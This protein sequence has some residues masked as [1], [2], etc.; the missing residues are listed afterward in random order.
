LRDDI[1]VSATLDGAHRFLAQTIAPE[2]ER[3]RANIEQFAKTARS[4]REGLRNRF[5]EARSR[6]EP[7]VAAA[8]AGLTNADDRLRQTA[9]SFDAWGDE[10]VSRIVP[11][12]E[13]TAALHG[14]VGR[15]FELIA[16][17]F[18]GGA[19]S[20]VS[21]AQTLER[22]FDALKAAL[23]GAMNQVEAGASGFE[24][25]L[26]TVQQDATSSLQEAHD[27]LTSF[28]EKC[29][30]ALD[31]VVANV[32]DLS[33]TTEGG[34]ERMLDETQSAV[35]QLRSDVEA[36]L[37]QVSEAAD[38]LN[39]LFGGGSEAILGQIRE[40]LQMVEKIRPLLDAVEQWT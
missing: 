8:E 3:Q 2:L 18:A 25:G 29:V 13:T 15:G 39:Q 6:I 12:K 1:D 16:Q 14:D 28:A 26:D 17:K 38:Q 23:S 33:A 37:E 35:E 27:K 22:L 4:L 20:A 36:T 24:G 19:E 10:S 40:L 9:Q 30:Q 32:R 34:V 31:E 11:A 5:E 7:L 21:S